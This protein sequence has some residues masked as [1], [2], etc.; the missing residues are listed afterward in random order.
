[1]H[2]MR[3]F[4]EAFRGIGLQALYLL[5]GEPGQHRQDT[6]TQAVVSPGAMN[7]F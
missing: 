5:F 1:M 4:N 7:F 3:L 6:D 2:S